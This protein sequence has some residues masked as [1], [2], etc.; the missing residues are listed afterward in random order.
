MRELQY[1][2]STKIGLQFNQRFWEKKGILGG[3]IITDL[4]IKIGYY[5]SYLI[6]ST[7]SGIL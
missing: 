1:I 4:P 5:P 2:A 6:G 7:G 3:K